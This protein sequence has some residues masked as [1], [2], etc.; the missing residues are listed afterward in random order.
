MSPHAPEGQPLTRS[1][2]PQVVLE[3][4]VNNHPGV[5]SHIC[6]LFAR[7]A[8]NLD[9]ILCQP[10]ADGTRSRIWMR[11]AA[12]ARVEQVIRHLEKLED[13][14]DVR[15]EGVGPVRPTKKAELG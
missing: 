5:M 2:R 12:D 7:R 9:G 14:I 3:L 11:I 4:T 1:E 6:G 10:I 13:V 15:R 8:F